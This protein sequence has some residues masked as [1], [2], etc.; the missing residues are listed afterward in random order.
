MRRDWLPLDKHCRKV[1][2]G[3]TTT[4]AQQITKSRSERDLRSCEVT[5][6]VTVLLELLH[7]CEDLFRFYSLSAVHPYDLYHIHFTSDYKEL[8][9]DKPCGA[10]SSVL[11]FSLP[12]VLLEIF[13]SR[14]FLILLGC[15]LLVPLSSLSWSILFSFTSLTLDC[16]SYYSYYTLL[17]APS[18]LFRPIYN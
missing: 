16:G 10:E 7:N 15:F 3:D 8:E 13:H 14:F 17:C 5:W 6:A 2:G 1:G 9:R 12:H 18:G 4:V 11:N